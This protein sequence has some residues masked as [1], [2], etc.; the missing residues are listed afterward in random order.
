MEQFINNLPITFIIIYVVCTVFFTS[1]AYNYYAELVNTKIQNNEINLTS[2]VKRYPFFT[3]VIL[4]SIFTGFIWPII[5][6][7]GLREQIRR[8]NDDNDNDDID[9]TSNYAF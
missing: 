7:I 1:I 2:K 8:K 5:F 6:L 4:I 9:N 3:I